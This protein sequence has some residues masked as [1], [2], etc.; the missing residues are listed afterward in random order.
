[1]LIFFLSC[2]LVYY[3]YDT[4]DNRLSIFPYYEDSTRK[5]YIQKNLTSV[6]FSHLAARL[7]GRRRRSRCQ[8]R[9][10]TQLCHLE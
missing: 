1:M 6:L 4:V 2:L 8:N 10:G 5:M 7:L 9:C 3:G